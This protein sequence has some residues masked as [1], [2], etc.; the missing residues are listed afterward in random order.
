ME[1]QTNNIIGEAS[2]PVIPM[3]QGIGM[4]K[5]RMGMMLALAV[6]ILIFSF[7]GA[8]SLSE[9]GQ[10]IAGITSVGGRTLEEAYYAE[11][12]LIYTGFANLL[13]AFGVF[14]A[15]LF[16]YLGMKEMDHIK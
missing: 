6:V 2:V 16:L 8:V 1:S 10:N 4:A 5:I 13:R 14:A 7:S 12:E 9:G 11:L 3:K 15:G